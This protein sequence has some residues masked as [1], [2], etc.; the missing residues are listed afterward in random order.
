MYIYVIN[1]QT[2]V[3]RQLRCLKQAGTII[4]KLCVNYSAIFLVSKFGLSIGDTAGISVG[5][6]NNTSFKLIFYEY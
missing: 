6:E 3:N 4:R 5:V 1:I 2:K